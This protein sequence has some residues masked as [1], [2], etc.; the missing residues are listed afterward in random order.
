M[1][2]IIGAD[3]RQYGPASEEQLRQWIAEGRV[4]ANTLVQTEGSTDW[5]P[6]ASVPEFAPPPAAPVPPHLPVARRKSKLAAGL[7]GILLGAWGIH[8]FYLGYIGVGIAQIL[9]TLSTCGIGALWGF[10]EGILIIA[11]AGI[12]TDARGATLQD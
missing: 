8:R 6:L 5:K 1:Y 2:K 9:V 4:D 7:L 11:G 10:I 3:G 12:T